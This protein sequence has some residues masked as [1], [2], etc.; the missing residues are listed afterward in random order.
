GVNRLAKVWALNLVQVGKRDAD[1][2]GS[3]DTLAQRY[4]KGLQQSGSFKGIATQLQL[5]LINKNIGPC[6]G[7]QTLKEGLETVWPFRGPEINA[8]RCKILLDARSVGFHVPSPDAS[9]AASRGRQC[10]RQQIEELA[11]DRTRGSQQS[12]CE[13]DRNGP[14]G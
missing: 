12:C 8:L 5:A 4:D 7:R 11:D 2:Q 1:D 10:T 14:D 3:F 13:R 6:C 9:G